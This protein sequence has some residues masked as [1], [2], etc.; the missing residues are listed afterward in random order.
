MRPIESMRWHAGINHCVT[1]ERPIRLAGGAA[2]SSPVL[3]QQDAKGVVLLGGARGPHTTAGDNEM[4]PITML[5]SRMLGAAFACALAQAFPSP[6]ARAAPPEPVDEAPIDLQGMETLDLSTPALP[7]EFGIR[8]PKTPRMPNLHD[9]DWSAKVGV[10]YRA[11]PI[12]AAEFRIEQLVAGAVRD[13]ST[14]VAW[15]NVSAPGLGWGKTV[16]ATRVDPLL[17]EGSFATTL[18]R[19]V[20]VGESLSVT[21]QNRATVTRTLA[22]GALGIESSQVWAGSQAVRFNI[23][24]ID[25][26]VAVDATI[27]SADDKW[28]RTISAERKLFGGPFSLTGTVSETQSGAPASSLTA[29]F[30]TTW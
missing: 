8:K 2:K 28:L 18:S 22:N 7:A 6:G 13:Q 26:T 1:Q 24:P 21:L 10:D 15:A 29:G 14:G 4:Q 16:I 17:D 3:G 20:P 19:A 30:K 11:P 5:R 9:A 23:L 12:P 27:S 25:T